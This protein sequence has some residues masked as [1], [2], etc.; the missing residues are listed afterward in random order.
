MQNEIVKNNFVV[1]PPRH[2][3]SHRSHGR[4]TRPLVPRFR[5]TLE[6]TTLRVTYG[7]HAEAWMGAKHSPLLFLNKH[8]IQY[9]KFSKIKS[10]C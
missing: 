2:T 9:Y 3:T 10:T 4:H 1:T 8:Q 5:T 7:V 6:L